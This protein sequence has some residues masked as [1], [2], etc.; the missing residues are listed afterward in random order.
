MRRAV[1]AIVLALGFGRTLLAGPMANHADNPPT[2][3]EL[4]QGAALAGQ[5]CSSAPEENSEIQTVAKSVNHETEH[6]CRCD[7]KY[8]SQEQRRGIL[9]RKSESEDSGLQAF[10]PY[11]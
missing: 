8:A 1:P 6:D 5:L 3:Q 10:T 9:E 11:C 7:S 2:P 4:A